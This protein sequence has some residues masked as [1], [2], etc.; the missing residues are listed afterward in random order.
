MFLRASWIAL[1]L[2]A[3]ALDAATVAQEPTEETLPVEEPPLDEHP[4]EEDEDEVSSDALRDPFFAKVIRRIRIVDKPRF[5]LEI[6]GKLH[7]QYYDADSDDS[8]NEDA[9]YVR[10]FRPFVYGHFLENWLWKFDLELSSEEGTLEL[11]TNDLNI[12]DAYVRFEGF[13]RE[14]WRLTGGN[15]KVPFSRDFMNPSTS[16][17]FPERTFV[18][19]NNVGV[20]S[21]GVGLHFRGRTNSERLV[22]WGSLARVVHT[23]DVDR[24]R[25]DSPIG[26]SSELNE[27][28]VSVARLDIRPR[29]EPVVTGPPRE[30]PKTY[31]ISVAAY[32]WSNDSGAALTMDGIALDPE[33]ADLDDAWGL[34]L[35]G[36][37][38][39]SGLR[40]DAELNLIHGETVVD[41][42]DGGI[43]VD[44][45]TDLR[46]G[47][48]QGGYYVLGSRL[49][50]TAGL[51]F[52]D[53]D[54]SKNTTRHGIVGLNVY[55]SENYQSK[56][57]VSHR[58]IFNDAGDPS[59][60]F[61]EI[62]IQLQYVW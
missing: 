8:D 6:G 20:P 31:T 27:G 48:L 19:D 49:E 29:G 34:E 55:M 46:V 57:Q 5:S 26:Q 52:I 50:A 33:R 25:W 53:S 10:R 2:A 37:L 30:Q 1:T 32:R 45:E 61:R 23:Q 24:M 3:F 42:F 15:Q 18:G 16:Q 9:L 28:L 22:F 7:L 14:G 58:W 60:D 54:S 13:R 39:G 17:L 59:A 47:A 38:Q 43:Y 40:L 21:R 4:L 41:D 35:S 11:S 56:L 12:R 36:G 62:R 51:T 44:G